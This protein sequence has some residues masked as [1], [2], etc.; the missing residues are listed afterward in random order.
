MTRAVVRGQ[1]PLERRP[2]PATEPSLPTHFAFLS[3][4]EAIRVEGA[5]PA[6]PDD[7]E[8]PVAGAIAFERDR[9]DA[10]L[11]PDALVVGLPVDPVIPRAVPDLRARITSEPSPATYERQV[12][13]VVRMIDDS[14]REGGDLEKVVIARRLRVVCD[15]PIDVDHLFARLRRDPEVTAFRIGHRAA[16]GTGTEWIGATP[17]LLVDKR[18]DRVRSFPLA[19]SAPRSSEWSVD[20]AAAQRL[21]ASAKEQ[22]EHRLV[23]EHVL[24]V[25]APYCS[26]L[27]ASRTPVLTGTS[28]V[29]HLGTPID[30]RL[31]D[32]ETPSLL[33]ARALHPTPA[34][35]GVPTDRAFELIA[36]I[37][38]APRGLYAG[39]VGW[40]DGRGDG[41]WM[42]TLRCAEIR[43]RTAILHAGAG[44]VSRSVPRSE[45]EETSAKFRALLD[46]FG[47]AEVSE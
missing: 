40:S 45:R 41:R 16:D 9:P 15:D 20:Q 1:E 25:L 3:R 30:G 29:W 14:L 39:A 19:G 26:A 23:V 4:T 22:T 13:E 11:A 27:S 6:G 46:A 2:P 17:E 21:L 35:C 36:G 8:G 42:V 12:A 47:V 10:L 7:E 5:R 37:E 44:L 33:L 31:R 34:V 38:G 43:G 32:P 18:G 28:T 24:D